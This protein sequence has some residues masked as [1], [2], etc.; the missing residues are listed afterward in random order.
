MISEFGFKGWKQ[1]PDNISRKYH[2]VHFPNGHPFFRTP[3]FSLVFSCFHNYLAVFGICWYP[4]VRCRGKSEE[5][6]SVIYTVYMESGKKILGY[7]REIAYF[8]KTVLRKEIRHSGFYALCAVIVMFPWWIVNCYLSLIIWRN[9]FSSY[10]ILLHLSEH[11]R[12]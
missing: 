7:A 4:C 8:S 1:L 5:C 10:Q 12:W 11:R 2:F 3:F 6:I 9:A